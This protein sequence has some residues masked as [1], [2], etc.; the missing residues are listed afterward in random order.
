MFERILFS[1]IIL[2]STINYIAQDRV[3]A[4]RRSVVIES[5]INELLSS[6]LTMQGAIAGIS[7]RSA[8]DGK[9]IYE[10][11][12]DV[13]LRPAS[14][15]K[16]LTAAAALKVLGEDYT[17]PTEIH[18]DGSVKKKTLAGN[19]YIKG[20]G[21]PTLMKENFDNLAKEIRKNGITKIKGNLIGD[22]SHFDDV[23]YPLDL[24]WSDETTYYGAQISALTASPT[25]DY[26]SGSVEV[27]VT[28]SSKAGEKPKVKITPETS[29]VKIVNHAVTVGENDKKDITIKRKHAKNTITIEGT[30]PIKTKA[31][32]EWV[33][34]WEP[35][36]YALALFKQSLEEQ[37]IKVSGKIKTGKVPDNAILIITH[38]SMPLSELLVP[39]MKLSNNVHAEM[40]VKEMG[41]VVLG[42][43]S[44]EKGLEVL[45]LEM[46]KFG[47]NSKTMVIRDG[48]GVSHVDLIPA[49][50]I[51][52]L[53][54]VV[55]KETWFSSYQNSLPVSGVPEK[56][57]GGSLRYRM[58][59]ADV[60]GRVK[61]K[62][63]TL[64]TVSSLSGYVTT[65]NGQ[66][67]IFSIILN[68]LLDEEKGK[69][70]ED[71]FVKILANQ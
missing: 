17:F 9:M 54:F 60:Q 7:I 15:M 40:L 2:F 66:T 26:D 27:I 21:D 62:T 57:A 44:W 12:G 13:R 69:K 36:R 34:V 56:M 68:N 33:G 20:K 10:Y 31:V 52:K 64:S 28:P 32:K 49:N 5:Q 19:L 71:E 41:K 50:E 48:S 11:N 30:V 46:V 16:L 59:T 8:E 65:K 3:I 58:K 70:L 55:Q 38:K 51:S 29:Y 24:P 14:N 39:F 1:F 47:L 53:L 18:I 42:E 35:T 43:G 67:L 63:G 4:E 37:G 25:T 22:D 6:S 61:A 23:R 45:N